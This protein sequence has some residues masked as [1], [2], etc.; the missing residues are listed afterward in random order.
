MDDDW[1]QKCFYVKVDYT[2]L[3]T[4]F[5]RTVR[6]PRMSLTAV[7]FCVVRLS[8]SNLNCYHKSGCYLRGK[9]I[10]TCISN[11]NKELLYTITRNVKKLHKTPSIISFQNWFRKDYAFLF[12]GQKTRASTR[13]AEARMK[14]KE[15][16][17]G[18]VTI[19]DFYCEA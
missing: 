18:S 10:D 4:L 12:Q 13:E 3:S 15:N 11:V 16:S 1:L 2:L 19:I 6:E 8:L 9:Y 14:S 7:G 17:S 5:P